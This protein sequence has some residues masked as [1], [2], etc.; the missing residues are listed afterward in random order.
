MTID[1]RL[2]KDKQGE[3]VKDSNCVKIFDDA[4]IDNDWERFVL[5][6]VIEDQESPYPP[7]DGLVAHIQYTSGS[8]GNPKGVLSSHRNVLATL[9]SWALFFSIRVAR[10][11]DSD[12]D[13]TATDHPQSILHCVPLFLSLIHI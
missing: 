13:Q 3:L 1:N 12:S 6:S 5:H 2:S 9:F 7:V 10:E 4:F 8:T 11:V